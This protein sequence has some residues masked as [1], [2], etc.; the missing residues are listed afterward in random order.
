MRRHHRLTLTQLGQ[1]D[2]YISNMLFSLTRCPLLLA[3]IPRLTANAFLHFHTQLEFLAGSS[4]KVLSCTHLFPVLTLTYLCCHPVIVYFIFHSLR[5][6]P[7]IS[8]S[9]DGQR[10]CHGDFF[11]NFLCIKVCLRQLLEH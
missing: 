9:K 1:E 8:R 5:T 10:L 6:W 2:K 7:S 11:F 3:A 4:L